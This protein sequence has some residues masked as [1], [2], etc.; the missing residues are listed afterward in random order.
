MRDSRRYG[1]FSCGLELEPGDRFR[2]AVN[3][4]TPN[5]DDYGDMEKLNGEWLTVESK[6]PSDDSSS[7]APLWSYRVK[8]EPRLTQRLGLKRSTEWYYW[9]YYHMDKIERV[10]EQGQR[11]PIQKKELLPPL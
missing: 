4:R 6:V 9:E 10:A 3:Y 5:T 2:V 7:Y 1:E 11:I 8:D